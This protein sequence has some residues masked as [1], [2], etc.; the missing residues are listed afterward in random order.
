[1]NRFFLK[2]MRI[3]AYSSTWLLLL[4]MGLLIGFLLWRGLPTINASLFWGDVPWLEAII[5]SRVVWD[6]IWPAVVGTLELIVLTV[7][8]TLFPGIGCGIFLAEYASLSQRRYLG[9]LIDILA[10]TPSIVMGLFGFTLIIFLR[11]TVWPT[12]N[13]CL[14]LA[15]GCLALL[16]LPVLIVTT[17]EAFSAVPEALRL[18]AISLGFTREQWIWSIQ[19]PAAHQGIWS[20][21][22]LALGRAAEDTAVILLTGVVANVG[23]SSGLGEK[24]EAL[25]FTIYYTAA[26]YQTQDELNKGFGA[27]VILLLLTA[28]LLLFARYLESRLHRY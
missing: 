27:A 5:G 8:I 28:G 6:G 11:H 25:P 26:Q 21:I 19:L 16:V 1:M 18:S 23:F 4:T 2:A 13:T 20:G 24:F 7:C 14:F 10:G 15:A 9:G 17:Q 12:A 3:V 22:V